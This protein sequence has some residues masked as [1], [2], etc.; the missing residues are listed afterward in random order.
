MNTIEAIYT[1]R[2]I[3]KYTGQEIEKGKIEEILKA[4]MYAPSAVNKRPWHFLVITDKGVRAEISEKHSNAHMLK[5]AQAGI[6]VCL[7]TALQ[8][9]DGYGIQDCSAAVQ[10]MLLA[11]HDMGLGTVWCGVFP[12]MNRVA[13]MKEMFDL[14]AGIE[15]FGLICLGYPAEEKEQPE[16]FQPERV[17]WGRW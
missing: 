5:N 6:L 3:R 7:E 15:P 13:D 1:R 16:R 9:D 4:G 12:R 10:N 17:H 8:H 14:P 11:A 2:S